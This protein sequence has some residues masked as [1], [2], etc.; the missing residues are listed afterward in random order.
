MFVLSGGFF[1]SYFKNARTIIMAL[2]VLPTI[3][4][5]SILWKMPR[6]N[7]IGCLFGYYIVSIPP[8]LSQHHQ[9]TFPSPQ[10]GAYVASLTIALQ[11][12][13]ANVGGYTKRVTAT[14]FVF[15]AYCIGNI[16]GPHAFLSSEAPIYQT[17]IKMI[18]A[19]SCCQF[20]LAVFLRFWLTK[21]NAERDRKLA[22]RG[23]ENA[24]E[25]EPMRDQTD[26][27]VSRETDCLRFRKI[28]LMQL[29]QNPAFRYSL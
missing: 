3:A 26:F 17:G 20:G 4:G 14:A 5:A 9:L 13:A 15:L 2:Y 25:D 1:A 23:G 16:V 29:L 11:M 28:L 8:R 10:V 24:G 19:C 6:S 22:E 7:T 12:P 21:R 18:L 27:E